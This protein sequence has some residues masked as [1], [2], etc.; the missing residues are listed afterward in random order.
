MIEENTIPTQPVVTVMGTDSDSSL[1]GYGI[2][3]Y[4]I[5][6]DNSS[7]IV[8]NMGQIFVNRSLDREV[9]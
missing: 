8:N 9:A 4:S 3:T 1:R 7:F 6:E 2:I 5:E